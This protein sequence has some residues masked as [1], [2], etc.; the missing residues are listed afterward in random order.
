M[1]KFRI[2]AVDMD[3]TVLNSEKKISR[4]N[5]EAFSL[6]KQKGILVVPVTGR[7]T[8]GMYEEYI[9]DMG[10]RYSINTNGAVVVD[11]EEKKELLSRTIKSATAENVLDILENFNC[12]YSLFYKGFGYL[13]RDKYDYE[14]NR[15]INTP[16]HKYIIKTRVPVENQR[17]FFSKIDHC[18]NIYVTAKTTEIRDNICKEIQNVKDIFFTCSDVDDVEIGGNCSKGKTLL[19]LSNLLGVKREE[20]LAIGDSGNDVSMLEMAGL[21]VAMGNGSE[22]VKNSADYVTKSCEENGVAFAI[23]KFCL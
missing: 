23:H 17:E 18:D 9:R 13:S 8:S 4:E 7:P 2:V 22:S 20:I 6:C 16:M 15:Y 10:C 1:G 14:L 19:E 12:Y 21:G 5:I 3:G 11:F